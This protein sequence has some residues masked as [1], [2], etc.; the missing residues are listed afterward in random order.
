MK[1]GPG[2]LRWKSAAIQCGVVAVVSAALVMA[3]SAVNF[4]SPANLIWMVALPALVGIL[5]NVGWIRRGLMTL[6]L[7]G[8]SLVSTVV[9]GVNFTNY[10]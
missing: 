5:A 8:V 10:G 9:I 4:R 2:I 6:A 7:M 3:T 1:D